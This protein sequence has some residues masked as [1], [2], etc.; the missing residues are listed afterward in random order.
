MAA[1]VLLQI[2]LGVKGLAKLPQIDHFCRG[3]ISGHCLP[4]AKLGSWDVGHG[5]PKSIGAEGA[6]I[7]EPSRR[8][9]HTEA[10]GGL[11]GTASQTPQSTGCGWSLRRGRRGVWGG[12]LHRFETSPTQRVSGSRLSLHLI[13]LSSS[14][15]LSR[16][17]ST[18]GP[19]VRSR[20]PEDAGRTS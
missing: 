11:Q 20:G 13:S 12:P 3:G 18:V 7:Q 6:Q 4:M 2:Q 9:G 14:T 10:T 15:I 1:Q 16:L 5:G 19:H 17:A 8:C